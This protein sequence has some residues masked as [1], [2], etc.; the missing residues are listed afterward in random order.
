M[1]T[2]RLQQ[3][4]WTFEVE[5]VCRPDMDIRIWAE[6]ARLLWNLIKA[7]AWAVMTIISC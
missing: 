2:S 3:Q 5:L 7:R 1:L 4:W 6:H